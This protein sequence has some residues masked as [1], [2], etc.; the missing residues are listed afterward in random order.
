MSRASITI[1]SNADRAK[2]AN[3]VAKAPTGTRVEFKASKRSIP[4]N[5]R[6]WVMLSNVASQLTWHGQKL[7][8]ND[9]KLLFLDALKREARVVPNLDGNGFIS[10]GRSSSDLSKQEMGDLLTI[11]EEFGARHGVVFGDD[12]ER[13]A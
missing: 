10:L 13:A 6:M 3:W 11:I 7:S 8:T 1:R 12:R 2:A 4:Q 5:D 9:W